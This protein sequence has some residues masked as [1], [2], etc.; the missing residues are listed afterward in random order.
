MP[1]SSSAR[2]SS[3]H[4]SENCHA[5]STSTGACTVFSPRA[6]RSKRV[7]V[8]VPA[9]SRV[10][11]RAAADGRLAAE[12]DAVAARGDDRRCEPELRVAARPPARPGPVLP[13]CRG[14]RGGA[15]RPRSARAP[16]ARRRA[17]S[18]S[19]MR[20]ARRSASPRRSSCRSTPGSATATRWPGSARSTGRSCTWTLRTRTSRPPGSARSTSPLA[21][22]SRPERP[23]RD[24]ADPAQREHAVDVEAG[25]V[26]QRCASAT[27][28]AARASAAAQ[29]VEPG[30]G[31]RAHRDDLGARDELPRLLD[32]ELERLRV[33]RVRLRDRDDAVLDPE[34]RAGSR[35]ARASAAAR[36]RRRRRRAGRGRSRSRPRPCCARSARGPGTSIEREAAAVGKLERRVAEVDRDPARAAPR[37]AGRCPCRSAPGRATSCRGRCGRRCRPS[38]ACVRPPP[39]PRRA[40]ASASVRQS[41]SVRPSRTTRDHRRLAARAARAASSSSTAQAKLGSSAS[42]SAPPPTRATVSSTV[43]AGRRRRAARRARAPPRPARA[44][45]AA[46]GSRSRPVEVE[47]ERPLERGER[48]LVGARARAGADGGA[49]ARRGRRGRRRSRPAARRAACRRRSRRGRRRRRAR[50]RASARPRARRARPSRGRRRA[51]ARARR[52]TAASSSSARLLGEADDAE[53][54]L[55][56]AQEQRGVRP[57]RA[58][59]V[60]GAR[61]VRRPDLDEARARA[62]EHVR[63]AEAVADLDQLAARDDDLAALG[64]RGEREQHRGRVVVDDERGLGAGQPP[65]ERREVVLARAARAA[66]EVVLEVR[67]AAPPRARARARP[68]RA[69]R[70]RGSC[71]GRRRS[72]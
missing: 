52:A 37:A 27:R 51:A 50:R 30:T 47:R 66:R 62:G 23:G 1:R 10:E 15:L 44:A 5:P 55:V 24:G 38:A 28:S 61:A 8:G 7:R 48:E 72:R 12:D 32:G 53:V 34:Q 54:R 40:S 64:E 70:G 33:D 2:N 42:G 45:S 9:R 69:A 36:P 49:G 68:R 67:V 71:A 39:R 43:A 35:G 18:S 46:P 16:R 63:D 57:D 20:R 3:S 11:H 60:G 41:S 59:V 56:H 29:L 25:R 22:R 14:G 26:V 13:R 58:L 6:A 21:D 65:Q 17:G 19:R 31:L 4:A